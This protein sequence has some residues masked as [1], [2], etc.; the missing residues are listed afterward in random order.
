MFAQ[1]LE[2]GDGYA[3]A[4]RPS[5]L[6]RSWL[7]QSSLCTVKGR[8]CLNRGERRRQPLHWARPRGRGPASW[9]HSVPGPGFLAQSLQPLPRP[10]APLGPSS[11][12]TGLA[13]GLDRSGPGRGH[14]VVGR[15]APCP[16]LAGTDRMHSPV[17]CLLDLHFR[18]L[19]ARR[20][21]LDVR[22]PWPES[23][24]G[25]GEGAAGQRRGPPRDAPRVP[26]PVR[27]RSQPRARKRP[28][29]PGRAAHAPS[30]LRLR[31]S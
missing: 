24:R 19:D 30:R 5:T 3:H 7:A 13:A 9:A 25:G 4:Q 23:V 31:D 6:P 28:T 8:A 16:L 22:S 21:G 12:L 29:L 17:H 15:R 10:R 2:R 18:R 11:G 1:R 27:T 14:L 20:A 26:R